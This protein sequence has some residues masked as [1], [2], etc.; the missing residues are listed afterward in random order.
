MLEVTVILDT[1]F[2]YDKISFYSLRL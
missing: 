2:S 1:Q